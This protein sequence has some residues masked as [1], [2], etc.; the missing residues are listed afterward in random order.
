MEGLEIL[1]TARQSKSAAVSTKFK[2]ES[3]VMVITLLIISV[4]VF[5]YPKLRISYL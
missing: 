4:K 2:F 5:N 3:P 1:S